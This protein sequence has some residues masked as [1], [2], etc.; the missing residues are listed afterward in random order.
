MRSGPLAASHLSATNIIQGQA[1][2]KITSYCSY[3]N[4]A[5][6]GI[7]RGKYGSKV[8]P[9]T[10]GEYSYVLRKFGPLP[11]RME[12]PKFTPQSEIV[13]QQLLAV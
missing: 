7:G 9:L 10:G 12:I 1:T 13:P 4:I 2:Y 5:G 8:N 3:Y 6:D 11:R